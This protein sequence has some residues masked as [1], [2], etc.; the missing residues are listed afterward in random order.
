VPG[1]TSLKIVSM[2]IISPIRRM[3]LERTADC[4]WDAVRIDGILAR[5]EGKDSGGQ[6]GSCELEG[7]HVDIRGV[8]NALGGS[9]TAVRKGQLYYGSRFWRCEMMI[10]C[11]WTKR[12][13][14]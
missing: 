7:R 5:C 8:D 3:R 10:D 12:Y 6:D 13:M 14:L 4:Q 9:L 11:P 2:G 1:T